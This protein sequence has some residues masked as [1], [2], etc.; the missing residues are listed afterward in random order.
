MIPLAPV[1]LTPLNEEVLL[2]VP[3]VIPERRVPDSPDSRILTFFTFFNICPH[4]STCFTFFLQRFTEKKSWTQNLTF[5]IDGYFSKSI[6]RDLTRS[7]DKLLISMFVWVFFQVAGKVSSQSIKLLNACILYN[8]LLAIFIVKRVVLEV[9]NVPGS[10]IAEC[11]MAGIQSNQM[12][13]MIVVIYVRC[14]ACRASRSW[15]QN[16]RC[17]LF[18]PVDVVMCCNTYIS[19][20]PLKIVWWQWI[21]WPCY[22]R[23]GTDKFGDLTPSIRRQLFLPQQ[24]T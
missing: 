5:E 19:T 12:T 24:V 21:P 11:R 15:P 16:F 7:A 8:K 6:L 14:K 9:K 23:R 22:V 17:I 2:S 1:Q 13:G 20:I 3:K 18:W 10:G 4:L